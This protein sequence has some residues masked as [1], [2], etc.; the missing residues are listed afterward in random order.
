MADERIERFISRY[1]VVVEHLAQA[2]EGIPAGKEL[3][4]PHEKCQA[5]IYLLSHPSTHTIIFRKVIEG[6]PDHGFPGAYRSEENRPD[7]GADA[8]RM[9]RERWETF[10]EWLL[11]KPDGFADTTFTVPWG[12]PDMTVADLLDWM[13]E[14]G[15][16][17]R[18]QAWIYAR[19]NGVKPP[20]VWGTEA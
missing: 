5:W 19:M 18:G 15:V 9:L 20:S 7:D 10:R 14:E 2:A 11:S 3:F 8:A 1:G 13:Y 6:N 17:H 4:A 12:W 16:H